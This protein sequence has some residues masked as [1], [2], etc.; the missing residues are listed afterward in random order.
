MFIYV[1]AG[2][3]VWWHS[4]YRT[5]G[6][7]GFVLRNSWFKYL[8]T[9][10]L[11]RVDCIFRYF[12]QSLRIDGGIDHFLLQYS[13]CLSSSNSPFGLCIV[14]TSGSGGQHI[15]TVLQCQSQCTCSVYHCEEALQF[16]QQHLAT[17]G[18]VGSNTDCSM[19]EHLLNSEMTSAQRWRSVLCS[20]RTTGRLLVG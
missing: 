2:A 8:S 17:W 9:D 18:T 6:R 13:D 4:G 14:A 15:V 5:C 1:R 20:S 3:C 10:R 19:R 12:P 7:A 16:R 11:W